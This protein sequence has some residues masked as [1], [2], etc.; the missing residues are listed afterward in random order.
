MH[1]ITAMKIDKYFDRKQKQYCWRFDFTL[2]GQRIRRGGFAKRVEAE[3]AVAAL[4]LLSDR[5]AYGLPTGLPV[6]SVGDLLARLE[7]DPKL[8]SNRVVAFRY[9]AAVVGKRTPI[10]DLTRAD[11]EKFLDHLQSRELR[12]A[13]IRYYLAL[14]STYL[15]NVDRYFPAFENYRPPRF[16]PRPQITYRHRVLEQ[17]EL[18]KLFRALPEAW[19]GELRKTAIIRMKIFDVARLMLLTGARREEIVKIMPEH[20]NRQSK[21]IILRSSKVQREHTIALSDTALEIL[22]ARIEI[23]PEG[24]K[25]F[26]GLTNLL[27][28]V[29]LRRAAEQAGIPYGQQQN[30]GWSLHDCRRTAA[31]IIEDAGIPYSAVMAQLGHKRNDMTARYT[32]PQME[33]LRRAAAILENWCRDIDGFVV[34]SRRLQTSLEGNAK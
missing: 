34:G 17:I 11:L 1:H 28:T 2:A 31:T 27:V 33:T 29:I 14:V 30:G 13:T 24:E 18:G 5:Q 4:R 15:R 20:I 32:V 21:T 25:L 12:A 26:D 7:Q 19:P 10:V 23:T 3:K 16:P 9:F 8:L 6:H 22:D